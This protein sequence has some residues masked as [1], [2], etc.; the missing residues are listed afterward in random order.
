MNTGTS[1][2]RSKR[3]KLALTLLISAMLACHMPRDATPLA[4]IATLAQTTPAPA[5]SSAN[6]TALNSAAG[7]PTPTTSPTP[8]AQAAAHI[9]STHRIYGLAGFYDHA[10]AQT[11]IPRGVN[12]AFPVPVLDHYEDRLLA[13]GV[14]DHARTLAD[15]SRLA[16]AG[17]NAVRILFDACTSGDGCIGLPNGEGLNPAYLDNLADLIKLGRDAHL[18]LV[19]VSS[20]LPDLGGYAAMANQSAS[21]QFAAGR[22]AATLT[23]TG[24]QAAQRYWSDVLVGLITRQAPLEIILGWELQ[25]EAYFDAGQPPFSLPTGS[26]TPADKHTYNLSD[27][28]Q[29]YALA[30]DGMRFYIT[31]LK[32][33][34]LKYDP[35]ALVTL[36]MIAPNEP[37]AWHAGDQRY[38]PTPELLQESDLD[39]YDL[40]ANPGTGLDMQKFA[41]DFGMGTHITK[42]VVMGSTGALTRDFP[43]V[44]AAA[45][46]IQDWIAASCAVGFSGWFYTGYYPSPA[47]LNQATWG[48]GDEQF[49]ILQALSPLHQADACQTTV[50]PG[51]NL[52]LGKPVTV[53][54]ALPDQPAQNAVDGDPNTQ[55]SAGAFPE[56]WIEIDLGAAYPIGEIRLTVGQWPAGDIVHQLWVGATQDAMQLVV[57]FSGHEVDYDVLNF[58]PPAGLANVRYV[59]VVTTESP[60]WVSWREIEILAP[61]AAPTP[62]P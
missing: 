35:T 7:S 14:Y 28:A 40:H 13:V 45:I 20:G 10:T 47:G 60:S 27:P 61:L 59:R 46:A 6:P 49:A 34:V 58:V 11:F 55:W 15:F 17:Y 18:Y 57:T 56:Q 54:A 1:S 52:A 48:F 19:L 29:K 50:L 8:V 21:Q 12:Y 25:D 9:I 43:Q 2:F 16:S 3:L 23:T 44:A 42:P 38:L 41:Q 32:S 62:T 31:Q 37:N 30:V 5:S 36:G 53:S 22:N 51:R 24:I 26:I 33:S 4:P 39:F